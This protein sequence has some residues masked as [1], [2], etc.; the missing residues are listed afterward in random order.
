MSNRTNRRSKPKNDHLH[1]SIAVYLKMQKAE[2]EA[3]FQNLLVE[4]DSCTDAGGKPRLIHRTLE[5]FRRRR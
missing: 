5:A 3:E 2:S 1:G 4:H